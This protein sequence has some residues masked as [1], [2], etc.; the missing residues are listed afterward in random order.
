MMDYP[1]NKYHVYTYRKDTTS[2]TGYRRIFKTTFEAHS[3]AEA[4]FFNIDWMK[5]RGV[6]RDEVS[7]EVIRKGARE[8]AKQR[9]ADRFAVCTPV[10]RPWQWNEELGAYGVVSW[11]NQIDFDWDKAE[12]KY[13][14][15]RVNFLG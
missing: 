8:I 1:L 14:V 9:G 3:A 12:G 2:K 6:T 4:L 7:F 13:P 5:G 15:R 11:L 10:I